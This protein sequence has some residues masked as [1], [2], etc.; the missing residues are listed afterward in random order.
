MKIDKLSAEKRIYPNRKQD[1]P[2]TSGEG[3]YIDS[4]YLLKDVYTIAER[5]V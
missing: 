2:L 4:P 5:S 3:D 1:I